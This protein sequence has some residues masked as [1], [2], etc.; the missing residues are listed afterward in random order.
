M[1]KFVK[2]LFTEPT[3]KGNITRSGKKIYHLPGG[4]LYE[5]TKA[6]EMFYTEEDAIKAGYVKSRS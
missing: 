5:F 3:I 4:N 2:R 6:E 1:F